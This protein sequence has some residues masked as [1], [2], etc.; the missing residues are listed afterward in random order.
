MTILKRGDIG[1]EVTALQQMLEEYD[2]ALQIDGVFGPATER[3]VR[4][5]QKRSNLVAD[6]IVGPKTWAALT[7]ENTDKLLHHSDIVA[8]AASLDVDVPTVM[9]VNEVESRGEGFLPD[10]RPVIL[11]ERHVMRRQ[12]EA[13]D[14][15]I[16]PW[17][18]RAPNIVSESPGGYQGGGREYIRLNNAKRI[19]VGCAINS[20]SWGSFQIMGYHHESLGYDS[21]QDW[22]QYMSESEGRHLDAFV[23][24]ILHDPALHRAMQE[25]DWQSFARRYNGPNYAINNY[26]RRLAEAH[27]RHST[28]GIT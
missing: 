17:E 27:Y 11:F 24:F 10:G 5:F 8:A 20:A 6:G 16:Q 9:A 19:D 13:A 3:S 15:P 28:G 12:M 2:I 22:E 14:I 1:S 18:E 25:H 4:Q 23:L 21:P 7:G 26:D